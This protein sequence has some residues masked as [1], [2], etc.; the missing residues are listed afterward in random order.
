MKS[1][2][3]KNKRGIYERP[4]NLIKFMSKIYE[5]FILIIKENNLKIII[6]IQSTTK[7]LTNFVPR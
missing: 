6:H 3:Y 4:L 7:L 2:Y 5:L 1:R